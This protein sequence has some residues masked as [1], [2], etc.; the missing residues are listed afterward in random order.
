LD[1]KHQITKIYDPHGDYDSNT[2]DQIEKVIR[3]NAGELIEI[4]PATKEEDMK[5]ATDLVVTVETG[6][7]AIRVRN[8]YFNNPYTDVT[9]RSFNK[10]LPTEIHKIRNG[11]GRWYLYIWKYSNDWIFYDLDLLRQFNYLDNKNIYNKQIPNYDGTK[12]IPIDI[13]NLHK[14]DIIV[15]CSNNVQN[16][17][18]KKINYSSTTRTKISWKPI[19]KN[20]SKQACLIGDN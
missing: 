5:Q 12:L 15:S 18:H 9:I 2:L 3:K 13:C 14:H 7:I 17:L 10:G 20:N 11:W 1:L 19:L 16:F 8:L 4:R 6:K